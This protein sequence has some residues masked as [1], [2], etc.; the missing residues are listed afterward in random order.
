[1]TSNR[2][3]GTPGPQPALPLP[4]KLTRGSGPARRPTL[5]AGGLPGTVYVTR[6][7]NECQL[8]TRLRTPGGKA[9]VSTAGGGRSLQA[10]TASPRAGGRQTS[11][12]SSDECPLSAARP[13][14]LRRRSL[15]AK[16]PELP[17]N[18]G[19]SSDGLALRSAVASAP[20]V[21]FQV[22]LEVAGNARDG[23]RDAVRTPWQ[24]PTADPSGHRIGGLVAISKPTR[25][26]VDDADRTA[27]V[28]A[29]R[30]RIRGKAQLNP[31]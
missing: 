3:Y 11:P 29:G 12:P 15:T 14:R 31:N 7:L 1:M 9:P 16:R 30:E 17:A 22:C 25:A 26:R 21:S 10:Q 6:G 19:L 20:T 28:T 5:Y 18:T 2:A 24:A 13:G 4:P 27:A 8:S 23:V